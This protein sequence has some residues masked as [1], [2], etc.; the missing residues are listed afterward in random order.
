[1][2]KEI[3][4][5]LTDLLSIVEQETETLRSDS[6]KTEETVKA[7]AQQKA[8]LDI[9]EAEL[10]KREVAVANIEDVIELEGQV[11]AVRDKFNE[12]IAQFKKETASFSDYR[13]KILAEIKTKDERLQGR[14]EKLT[15]D[16]AQLEEDKRTYREKILAQLRKAV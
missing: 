10:R 16:L 4:K 11:K 6:A 9:K 2:L 3:A 15:K 1:M 12:D 7:L 13:T 8:S 5:Q 14:E